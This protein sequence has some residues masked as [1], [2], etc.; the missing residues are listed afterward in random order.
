MKKARLF[1][2]VLALAAGLSFPAQ[3]AP[4]YLAL[5]VASDLAFPQQSCV[6]LAETALRAE[7]FAKI[8]AYPGGSTVFAAYRDGSDYGYKAVVKCLP[9][10]ALA[11]VV[12]VAD[13]RKTIRAKAARIAA[14]LRSLAAAGHS[15]VVGESVTAPAPSVRSNTRPDCSNGPALQHCLNTLPDSSVGDVL[16]Y[17]HDLE[18]PR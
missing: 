12:V 7:D 1:S 18:A 14:R 3:A 9:E 8:D 13:S 17:L 5:E 11:T 16:Q 4:P 15:P 10:Q 2:L 6:S